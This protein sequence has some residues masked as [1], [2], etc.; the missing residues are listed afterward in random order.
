[1][2][3]PHDNAQQYQATRETQGTPAQSLH[4]FAERSD[5]QVIQ[6][7]QKQ[8]CIRRLENEQLQE[9]GADFVDVR[10]IAASILM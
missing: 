1:M 9:A 5:A 3:R 6:H 10:M 2:R 4:G 8:G 7:L